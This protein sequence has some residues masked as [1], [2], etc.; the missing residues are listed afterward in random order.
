MEIRIIRKYYI[1]GQPTIDFAVYEN[2]EL[3]YFETIFM[4]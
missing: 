1:M 2:G 4:G 3:I